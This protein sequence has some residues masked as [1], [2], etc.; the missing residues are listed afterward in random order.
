MLQ[1]LSPAAGEG[2]LKDGR[3]L[4][5]Q[6]FNVHSNCRLKPNNYYLFLLFHELDSGRW[7]EGP[8]AVRRTGTALVRI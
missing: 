2:Q 1:S 6:G 5:G 7:Y 4:G 3:H 8:S